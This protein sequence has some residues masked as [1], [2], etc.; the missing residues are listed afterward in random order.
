MLSISAFRGNK[1]VMDV[2]R[3]YSKDYKTMN[4]LNIY[5]SIM[6]VVFGWGFSVLYYME[7]LPGTRKDF[8][9]EKALNIYNKAPHFLRWVC[10]I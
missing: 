1:E 6:F 3:S 2:C 4:R 5:N 10:L 9:T 8:N 7:Y